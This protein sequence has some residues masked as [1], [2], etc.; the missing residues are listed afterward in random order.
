MLTLPCA[1]RALSSP[2]YAQTQLVAPGIKHLPW[3]VSPLSR[4]PTDGGRGGARFPAGGVRRSHAGSGGWSGSA[5]V[6]AGGAAAGS[7]GRV[8]RSC[9]PSGPV[10]PERMGRPEPGPRSR[11]PARGRRQPAGRSLPRPLRRSPGLTQPLPRRPP[12]AL[13][14]P[15]PPRCPWPRASGSLGRPEPWTPQP[16]PPRESRHRP[17]RRVG[18][19]GQTA[20]PGA[21]AATAS[22]SAWAAPAPGCSGG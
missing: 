22:A 11:H 1:A 5:E 7:G 18:D 14:A 6:S 19:P 17:P 15:A 20:G 9:F 13:A 10:V 2:S 16:L 8:R 21:G 3:A 12:G 4:S